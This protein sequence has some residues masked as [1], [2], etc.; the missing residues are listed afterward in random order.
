MSTRRKIVE[1]ESRETPELPLHLKYRPQRWKEVVGQDAIVSSLRDQLE[2]KARQHAYVL[3]GPSGTGKTTLARIAC[4]YLK[5]N[6][7]NL[8]EVDA[9]S[10]TGIDDMRRVMEPLRYKGMGD[11]P[12]RAI[13]ID[14]AHRLSKQA[15]DS[16]L[17][18][19]E[20]P[21]EHVYWFFCTTDVG[22]IP[23]AITTRCA[24]Y[25]LRTVGYD[26]L[27][28]LLEYVREKEDLPTTDRVLQ[29]ICQ[30]CNGS[31][32][33]ALVMLAQAHQASDE[34]E[35]ARLFETALENKEVI[36][37]ARL[38]VQGQLSWDKM[39]ATLKAM[40]E[41]NAESIR[42]VIVAYLTTCLMG[43]QTD[44]GATRLLDMLDAFSQPYPQTDKMAPL[45][46]SFGRII[47]P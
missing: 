2:A 5:I 46:L 34:E 41:M 13:I 25:S 39:T 18:S 3:A 23:A 33:Q 27:I 16:L 20:E 12:N 6:A 36:D 42:I 35:A 14:E 7:T 17:K 21:P 40:P 8:I 15:W 29:L 26:D 19:V 47:Y 4:D 38:L 11:S 32:R 1:E 44:K 37:L 9:A 43:K 22:K 28:E 31:P 45:L 24:S 30:S 10:N